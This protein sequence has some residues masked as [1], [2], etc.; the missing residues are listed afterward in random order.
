MNVDKD[1]EGS[2]PKRLLDFIGPGPGRVLEIGSGDGRLTWRYAAAVGKVVGLDLERD[3]LRV[4]RIERPSDLEARVMFAQ[5]DSTHLPA[6]DAS[7]DLAL[8]AW[9]F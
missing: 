2:E 9:S 6:K 4:A 5:A 8:F 3:D 1:P 7:F